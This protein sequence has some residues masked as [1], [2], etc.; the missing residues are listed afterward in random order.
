MKKVLI[1]SII[2]LAFGLPAFGEQTGEEVLKSIVKIQAIIPKEA[3]TAGTLGTE[4]E[5]NGVIIDAQGHILTTGYL[6]I[7]A[8][9]I[10]VSVQG[11]EK[12]IKAFFVGYDHATGFGLLRT[13]KP[14][15][16]KPIKIGQSG[17]IKE[18]TPLLIASYGGKEAA[19]VVRVISRKEFAGYWEYLLEEPF[20]T[21]PAF[22]NYG[23]AA[24]INIDGELVGIGSLLSQFL[25]P[26]L[27]T[28]PCNV[29]IPIDLLNPI[30]EDLITKSRPQK[31]PRPWLGINAEEAHG[32]IFITRI[33]SGGPAEEDLNNSFPFQLSYFLGRESQ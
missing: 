19:Q 30:L 20:Y 23:G 33:I 18:G 5:G 29:S 32:R 31:E 24:L 21:I 10:Q 22:A 13:E 27:G 9:K 28:V 15:N 4:R 11:E 6:I 14:C 8:E 3:F 16:V 7:E 17:K 1:I 25:I 26:G 2:F 12:P